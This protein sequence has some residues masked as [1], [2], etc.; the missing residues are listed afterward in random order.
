[1]LSI[2][3]LLV[4]ILF[5]ILL[6]EKNPVPANVFLIIAGGLSAGGINTN[7]IA[8]ITNG[9]VTYTTIDPI[10]SYALMVILL[11]LALINYADLIDKRRKEKEDEY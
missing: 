2:L 3:T 8:S 1:M 7:Q 5:Y 6:V 11:G 9:V 10:I 4:L